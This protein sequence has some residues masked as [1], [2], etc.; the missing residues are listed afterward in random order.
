MSSLWQRQ[1]ETY[2]LWPKNIF[3]KDKQ[4]NYKLWKIF[5]KKNIREKIFYPWKGWL[6]T[7]HSWRNYK[8][9]DRQIEGR[10]LTVIEQNIYAGYLRHW[11]YNS[12][13]YMS[14]LWQQQFFVNP[15]GKESL[16]AIKFIFFS[17]RCEIFLYI[18]CSCKWSTFSFC[19]IFS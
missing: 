12:D 6:T 19:N 9:L 8:T 11:Q 17:R 18:I 13:V 15:F 1:Y 5:Y 2:V 10:T 16:V 14:C 3:L 7:F 4:P